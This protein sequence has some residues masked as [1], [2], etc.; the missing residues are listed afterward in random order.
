MLC[1]FRTSLIVQGAAVSGAPLPGQSLQITLTQ[2]APNVGMSEAMKLAPLGSKT[3]QV[4]QSGLLQH[5]KVPA[6]TQPAPGT[7]AGMGLA[8]PHLQ[9]QAVLTASKP[10]EECCSV[11]LAGVSGSRGDHSVP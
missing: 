7:L 2:R 8:A 4:A 1:N 3:V 11:V 10:G 5:Q 6:G 9:Q